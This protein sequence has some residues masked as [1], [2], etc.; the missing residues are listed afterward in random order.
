MTGKG[1]IKL[2]FEDEE[3]NR[4]LSLYNTLCVTNLATTRSRF[5]KLWTEV[6]GSA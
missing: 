6:F 3:A 5:Q 1:T 2:H 4:K